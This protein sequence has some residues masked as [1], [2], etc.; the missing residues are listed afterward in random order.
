[1]RAMPSTQAPNPSG[2]L[3]DE[4][5]EKRQRALADAIKVRRKRVRANILFG[6]VIFAV[7]IVAGLTVKY[8]VE[9]HR[10]TVGVE[11]APSRIAVS[12]P[13]SLDAA[14]ARLEQ[15]LE[16]ESSHGP[17]L[18]LLAAVKTHQ[19]ALGLADLAEAQ[20][21][22]EA[23]EEAGLPE[24]PLYTG[25]LAALEGDFDRAR[26]AHDAV[27]PN[28]AGVVLRNDAAWLEGLVAV[29]QPY[30]KALGD[31]AR[32]RLEAALALDPTWVPN[33]RLLGELLAREGKVDAALTLVETNREH[34]PDHLGLSVDEAVYHA[35]KAEQL[36]GVTQL[37]RQLLARE[38]TPPPDRARAGLA[39]GISE[40]HQGDYDD[41]VKT[42]REAWAALPRWDNQSR[43]LIIEALLSAGRL[44]A[45]RELRDEQPL[46]SQ[47][48]ALFDAW[49]SLMEARGPEALKTL[50]ALPQEL[51]RVAHLTALGLVEEGRDD[52]AVRWVTYAQKTL[53]YRPDLDIAAARLKGRVGDGEGLARLQALSA[54]HP[55]AFRVWTGLGEALVAAP[56]PDEKRRE[57]TIEVLERAVKRESAPAKASYLLAERQAELAAETPKIASDAL[58]AYA[59]ATKLAP[60]STLYKA[61]YGA[62]LGEL[63]RAAQAK[64]SL[65]DAMDDASLG[66]EPLIVLV[67]VVVVDAYRR[68]AP[69]PEM[70]SAWLEEAAARGGDPWELELEWARFELARGTPTS[71]EQA[72][73]RATRL[74]EHAPRNID[75][76]AILAEA[77]AKQ[78]EFSAARDTLRRGIARTLKKLDGP[79][80][81]AW[82]KVEL[83]DRNKR[84]AAS[85]AYKGWRKMVREPRP[86]VELLAT[87]PFVAG[88][89]TDLGQPRA[90]GTVGRGLVARAPFSSEAWVLHGQ[91]QLKDDAVG[92]GCEAADKAVELDEDYAPG[93][94]L[95]ADCLLKL[96]KR[97]EARESLKTA[98]EKAKGTPAAALYKRRL[99]RL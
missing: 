47:A 98:V 83:A 2:S 65:L 33:R 43:M 53:P 3:V 41:G 97:D 54:A 29:G 8:F 57:R 10:L 18:G 34:A 61:K 93:W 58:E 14:I 55:Y 45:A 95:R 49:T 16:I 39:L 5:Y 51:P 85:L 71:L 77:L 86:A 13:A 20:S 56:N 24:A 50:G 22:I 17:T 32:A 79:L 74:L 96:R 66:P 15:N 6:V 48:D 21:A 31:E 69:V 36:D 88:L 12:T 89:W 63:G 7:L 78:R 4:I 99:K 60:H 75:G 68:Q 40:L 76:R 91:V 23:A 11:Q 92:P 44:E 67:R 26:R 84:R 1:M 46:G 72:V 19:V 73:A 9:Q 87:A 25:M 37:A 90:A 35:L 30:D 81:V 64:E 62:Y 59:R 82:A 70:A 80:Y 94:A 38:D 42:L 27:D 52:E 28:V